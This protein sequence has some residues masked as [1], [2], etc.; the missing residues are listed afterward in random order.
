MIAGGKL[1]RQ[2]DMAVQDAAHVVGNRV[3]NVIALH[4]D[5]VEAR[6]ASFFRGAAML[7]VVP[8]LPWV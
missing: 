2:D 1:A 4:Q 6:D 3:I 8:W 7:P 5:G